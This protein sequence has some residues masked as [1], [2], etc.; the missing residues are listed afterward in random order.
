MNSL[1]EKTM[2]DV[3]TGLDAEAGQAVA[4]RT[5]RAVR[6]AAERMRETRTRRRR[7][8]GWV[9]LAAFVLLVFLTPAIWAV[10]EGVFRGEGWMGEPAVAVLLALTSASMLAAV[11]LAEWG[12][13]RGSGA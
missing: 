1:P 7:N 11:L 5:R 3:L 6:E 4:L 12:R 13:A 10:C 2:L 9:L 8:A